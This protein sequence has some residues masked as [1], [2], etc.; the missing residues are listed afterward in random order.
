MMTETR[1]ILVEGLPGSDKTTT[2]Q[3]IRRRLQQDFAGS[4]PRGNH[5]SSGSR[6][7]EVIVRYFLSRLSCL[8]SPSLYLIH[9]L[10]VST[11]SGEGQGTGNKKRGDLGS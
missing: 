6:H 8:R 7:R 5:L 4:L 2:A 10:F 11:D 3:W 9:P 1:L